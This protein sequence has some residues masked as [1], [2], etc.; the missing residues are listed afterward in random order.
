MIVTFGY[1]VKLDEFVPTFEPSMSHE[2]WVDANDNLPIYMSKSFFITHYRKLTFMKRFG[3]DFSKLKSESELERMLQLSGNDLYYA[4]RLLTIKKRSALYTSCRSQL[5]NFLKANQ[6][7]PVWT[8]KQ[9][10]CLSADFGKEY[11]NKYIAI[12]KALNVISSFA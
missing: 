2:V 4:C 10:R 11:T 3:F 6:P 5:L 7:E 12:S 9:T 8:S 1:D